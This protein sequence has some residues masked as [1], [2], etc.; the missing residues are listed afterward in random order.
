MADIKLPFSA[1][2]ETS[3]VSYDPRR[4]IAPA[5]APAGGEVTQLTQAG[6][7]PALDV[8]STIDQ[9]F[10][11]AEA[12]N[13][14]SAPDAFADG[15]AGSTQGELNTRTAQGVTK[16]KAVFA[17]YAK[18]SDQQIKLKN[19][20]FADQIKKKKVQQQLNQRAAN[21]KASKAL[22]DKRLANQQ[23]SKGAQ[24]DR[25]K[26][27]VGINDANQKREIATVAKTNVA[28][29]ND[30]QT[31]GTNDTQVRTTDVRANVDTTALTA[32]AL[33]DPAKKQGV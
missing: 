22:V 23:A 10:G 15:P 6:G 3:G 33:Q 18:K 11:E 28:K 20:A 4:A 24:A 8:G 19:K 7:K 25:R 17:D 9:Q 2:A 14:A 12:E 27:W 30:V 26:M 29:T 32:A 13:T 16:R 31:R 1:G 5:V 21:Q